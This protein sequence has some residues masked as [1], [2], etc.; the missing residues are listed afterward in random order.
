VAAGGVAQWNFIAF[1]HNEHQ[2]ETAKQLQKN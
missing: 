1:K 2:V